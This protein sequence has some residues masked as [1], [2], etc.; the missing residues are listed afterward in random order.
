[1]A[2][3]VYAV[4]K[5]F[6]FDNNVEVENKIV[7]TWNEC[8]K[9]VKGVKGAE[10]KSFTLTTEAQE[11]LNEAKSLLKKGQDEYPLDQYHAYVDGSFNQSSG[12]F[13]YALVVVKDDVIVHIENGA[14]ENNE[15]QSIRQIA[16]ELLGAI[17]A[18]KYAV[19]NNLKEIV[20]LHDYVGVCY[21][22]T[23]FWE[24]KEKSSQKYYDDINK[25]IKGN[26]LSVTF[27]KVDSHT[28]DLFN[29]IVDEFAKKA[30]DIPV[31]GETSKYLKNKNIMVKSHTI[32]EKMFEIVGKEVDH[33]IV[34]LDETEETKIY[35]SKNN[36]F[37][38]EK[39]I[40]NLNHIVKADHKTAEESI[41]ELEEDTKNKL[42]YFL[43]KNYK[44]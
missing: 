1:M 6:D 19:E 5:G 31:K 39:I 44:K 8:L 10:Y 25:I 2:K 36:N 12:L 16:G 37:Q 28:G 21:H 33:N 9:L 14:A 43:I 24:R 41:R 23:G 11:Y 22:A 34:I 38:L 29:E 17:R 15:Q 13:S 3:K 4:K 40:M 30:V 7:Q 20:I 18:V 32:K 42:L 26:D 27:V 35:K